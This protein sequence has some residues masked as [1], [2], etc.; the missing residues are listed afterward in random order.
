MPRPRTSHKKG[1]KPTTAKLFQNGRSQAVRLP[2]AFRFEEKEVRIRRTRR[3]VLLE[4]LLETTA[5]SDLD[6]WFADLAFNK[7]AGEFMPGGRNQPEMPYR[8]F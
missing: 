4:P 2:L 1:T 3:G 7:V 6:Q 5:D 8:T